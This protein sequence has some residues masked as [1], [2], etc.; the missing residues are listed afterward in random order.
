M[1]EL[2]TAMKEIEDKMKRTQSI[3]L[4]ERTS[5]HPY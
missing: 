5:T 4:E 1:A 2:E 3:P